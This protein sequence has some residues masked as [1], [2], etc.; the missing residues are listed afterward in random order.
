MRALC[1]LQEKKRR[2][3]SDDIICLSFVFFKGFVTAPDRGDNL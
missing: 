1:V 2:E 3:H